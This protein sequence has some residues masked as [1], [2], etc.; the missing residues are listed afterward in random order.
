MLPFQLIHEYLPKP[1]IQESN[2]LTK[3]GPLISKL[4]TL[5]SPS[6]IKG[7]HL[8]EG[9]VKAW[10]SYLGRFTHVTDVY[11]PRPLWL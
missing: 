11:F 6:P 4:F 7:C 3:E 2:V 9:I 5:I 8:S 10:R 1:I